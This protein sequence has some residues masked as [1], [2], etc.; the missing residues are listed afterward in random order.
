[1]LIKISYWVRP[2]LA[3]W[4]A[5]NRFEDPIDGKKYRKMLPYG[6]EGRQRQNALSPSSLS[7]ERHRLLWLYL[8][9]E[10]DFFTAPKKM[11][12]VAPEQC[13]YGLFKK[14]KN[15]DYLTADIDSPLADVKM[16]IHNI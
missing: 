1:L 14:M 15:L 13:F 4:Y 9:E 2:L 16:D 5:G 12:H 10:T 6:Y 8:K 11:L 7:L 3:M